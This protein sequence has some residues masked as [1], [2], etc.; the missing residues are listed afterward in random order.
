[1]NSMEDLNTV[2]YESPY[3]SN[4]KIDRKPA[5]YGILY[6]INVAELDLS[7]NLKES[8]EI[9]VF[10]CSPVD[11]GADGPKQQAVIDDMMPIAKQFVA[12][13][14]QDKY[15]VIDDTIRITSSYAKFDK[16]VTGVSVQ[17]TIKERQ[18]KCIDSIDPQQRTLTIEANGEYDVTQYGKVIVNVE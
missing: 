1:M 14:K 11:F 9:E 3:F 12:L 13:M 18:S 5:P 10:F 15:F 4:I 6:L 17:M 16:N 7:N 2:L 8:V